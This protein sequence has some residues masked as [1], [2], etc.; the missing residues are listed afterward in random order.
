MEKTGRSLNPL[1]SGRCFLHSPAQPETRLV[2]CLNPL[3]SGRCF[4]PAPNNPTYPTGG[5]SQ[6]P[7]I[8]AVFPT[9]CDK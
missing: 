8:G 1:E 2:K 5:M 3:E 6:S 9:V 4:L 7:R